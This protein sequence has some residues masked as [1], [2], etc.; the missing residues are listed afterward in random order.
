M[1]SRSTARAA[2]PTG[3]CAVRQKVSRA[4]RGGALVVRE[5]RRAREVDRAHAALRAGAAASSGSVPSLGGGDE[6]GDR[7][8]RSATF[9]AAH[10]ASTST[11]CRPASLTVTA[12]RHVHAHRAARAA[13]G[14]LGGARAAARGDRARTPR[15]CAAPMSSARRRAANICAPPTSAASRRTRGRRARP[16]ATSAGTAGSANLPAPSGRLPAARAA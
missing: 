15:R 3:A 9:P 5:L 16:R 8:R 11:R 12:R 2:R 7:V 14:G 13:A 10:A 6:R 1:T 4:R